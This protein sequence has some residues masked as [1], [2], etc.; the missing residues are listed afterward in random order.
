MVYQ[1]K[2]VADGIQCGG[3]ALLPH[4]ELLKNVISAA[5]NAPSSKV[6]LNECPA[7]ELL[8]V[9]TFCRDMIDRL[10]CR[11]RKLA[12]SFDVSNDFDKSCALLREI[13]L[14]HVNKNWFFR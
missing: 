9:I 10:N 7:F 13:K 5:F 6:G 2:A 8:V 1:L 12:F 14:T 11:S 3:V 4:G